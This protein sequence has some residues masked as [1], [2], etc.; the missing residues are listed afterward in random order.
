MLMNLII[1]FLIG[2]GVVGT[3]HGIFRILG[4]KAPRWLLPAAAGLAMIGYQVWNE[5]TW[6]S[7]TT[8]LLPETI[9]VGQAYAQPSVFKPW[10]YLIASTDRF[11]A[12][13][14]AKVR[15]NPNAPG[16]VLA[17]V[18]LVSQL[19]ETV[20]TLQIFD[21]EMPRRA[22]IAASTTFG[23]DGLPTNPEWI[24]LAADDPLRAI[25]CSVN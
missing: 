20:T 23:E 10:S 6:F 12:I 11:S 22:D 17:E 15:R 14:R 5:Y 7:R 21:C 1:T 13:D 4:R 18:L 9:V 2:V 16:Y 19:A 3:L 8:A 24:E 25:A